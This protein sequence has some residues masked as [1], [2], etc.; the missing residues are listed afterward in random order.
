MSPRY[1]RPV[2]SINSEQLLWP[3]QNLHK[4]QGS[5]IA[6]KKKK[7]EEEEG[8]EEEKEGRRRRKGTAK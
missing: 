4:N 8:V 5:I 7:K 2:V 1:E 6:W 3:A